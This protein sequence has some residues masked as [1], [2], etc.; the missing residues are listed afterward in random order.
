MH[1]FCIRLIVCLIQDFLSVP[2]P[3]LN[4][5]LEE[6][7]DIQT[8]QTQSYLL[9]ISSASSASVEFRK[10]VKGTLAAHY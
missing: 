3:L 4:I 5:K 1:S 10:D 9:L 7:I 8:L 2:Y 6:K